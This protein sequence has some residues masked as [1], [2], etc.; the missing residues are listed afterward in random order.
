MNIPGPA[1]RLTFIDVNETEIRESRGIFRD[2]E[3]VVVVL[4]GNSSFV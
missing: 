3:R 1:D 4:V 2:V